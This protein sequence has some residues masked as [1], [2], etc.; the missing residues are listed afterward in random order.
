MDVLER[1]REL[2]KL[3]GWSYY[4]VAKKAG[5]SDGAISTMYRRNTTPT[6]FTLKQ[7]CDAFGITLSQFF[8]DENADNDTVQLTPE[9]KYLFDSWTELSNDNKELVLQLIQALR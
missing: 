8:F 6:V 3:Y 1:L 5:L 2:Q 4:K 9:L 7:I